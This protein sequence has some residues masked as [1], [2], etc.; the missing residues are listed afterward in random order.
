MGCFFLKTAVDGIK[1]IAQ[2]FFLLIGIALFN[3]AKSPI[4]YL[5][6]CFVL[7]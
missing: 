5:V 4:E 1:H 2:K 6:V 7:F 3:F